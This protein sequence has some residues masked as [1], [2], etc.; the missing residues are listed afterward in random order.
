MELKLQSKVFYPSHGAGWVK[1]QK[2]IEFSGQ[3]KEY[4]EFEFINS[5]LTISAPVENIDRLGIRE[6]LKEKEIIKKIMTL[7]KTKTMNPKT[8][9]FNEL[10]SL[11]NTLESKGD[12]ETY[13]QIIQYCNSI[14]KQRDAEGR[15]IPI[16][17]DKHV[18]NSVENIVAELAVTS[19]TDLAR[20]ELKFEKATGMKVSE[21]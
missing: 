6:V 13:I 7:K 8:K 3:Q 15:L 9:D 4:Y 18:K 1:A 19:D 17:I 14:K 2:V 20:A 21:L 12:I 10:M 5:P 16:S 11:L